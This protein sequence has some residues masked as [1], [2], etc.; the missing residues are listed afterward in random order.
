[1]PTYDYIFVIHDSLQFSAFRGCEGLQ[2]SSVA[3]GDS[4]NPKDYLLSLGLR[5]W[6]G[7]RDSPAM[8]GQWESR[9]LLETQ[10]MTV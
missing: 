3:G 5:G 9:G 10:E 6:E 8:V 7:L 2:D 1:M 4:G